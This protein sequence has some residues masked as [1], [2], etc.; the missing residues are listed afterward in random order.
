M[1]MVKL[2]LVCALIPGV[3]SAAGFSLAIGPPVAAGTGTKVTK[4]KSAT[5]AVRLEECDGLA[6]ARISGT[7][8]GLVNGARTSAPVTLNAAASAGVYLVSQDWASEGVWVVSLTATCGNARAGAIVPMGPQG[9]LRE[10]TR[11]LPRA[12]TP[13]EVDSALKALERPAK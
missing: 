13:A 9:F 3:A 7:A 1:E 11:V 12:A 6:T 10:G 2:L 8:E 4:T 5:F